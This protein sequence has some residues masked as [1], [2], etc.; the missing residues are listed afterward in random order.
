MSSSGWM[1]GRYYGLTGVIESLVVSLGK[2]VPLSMLMLI[3][4]ASTVM[5]NKSLC[6]NILVV[7][8]RTSLYPIHLTH[9]SDVGA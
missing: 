8:L 7:S 4:I 9:C 2:A 6:A 3:G 5:Y 1:V